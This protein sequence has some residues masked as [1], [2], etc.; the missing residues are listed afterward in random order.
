MLTKAPWCIIDYDSVLRTIEDYSVF[1]SLQERLC[2]A[3]KFVCA[4][5]NLLT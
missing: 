1:Q 5:T 3:V 4:N 2:E